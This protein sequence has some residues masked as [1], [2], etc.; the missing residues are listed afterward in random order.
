MKNYGH[1]YQ[2]QIYRT[3]VITTF[4]ATSR[5]LSSPVAKGLSYKLCQKLSYLRD[6]IDLMENFWVCIVRPPPPL[7]LEVQLLPPEEGGNL[8]KLKKWDKSMVQG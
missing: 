6:Q 8:K 4:S 2:R 1:S 5:F 7:F 3:L